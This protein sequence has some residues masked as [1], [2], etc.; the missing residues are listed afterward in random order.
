MSTFSLKIGRS[1]N[2][3][4]IRT[5]DWILALGLN[6][7]SRIELCLNLYPWLNSCPWLSRSLLYAWIRTLGLNCDWIRTLLGLNCDW[8]RTHD[9]IL[10][11][12]LDPY[13]RIGLPQQLTSGVRLV[14]SVQDE[15]NILLLSECKSFPPNLCKRGGTSMGESR[16]KVLVNHQLLFSCRVCLNT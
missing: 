1:Q 16:D 9:W 5:H 15:R 6:P 8:I 12:G 13:S 2:C 11:L 7:C 14:R 10:T 3:D 4:W